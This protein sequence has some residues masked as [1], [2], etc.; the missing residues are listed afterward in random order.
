LLD[1]FHRHVFDGRDGEGVAGCEDDMVKCADFLE[2]F[3][4]IGLEC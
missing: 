3:L 2:E 1:V 4:D